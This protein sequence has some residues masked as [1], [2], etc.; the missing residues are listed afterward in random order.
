MRYDQ[1]QTLTKTENNDIKTFLLSH[2]LL[3]D[4]IGLAILVL[5]LHLSRYFTSPTH[6][7]ATLIYLAIVSNHLSFCVSFPL[8]HLSTFILI[9]TPISVVSTFLITYLNN[10][11]LFFLIL[12]EDTSLILPL[13][14][15]FYILSFFFV[16]SFIHL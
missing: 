9:T 10:L 16:T 12:S 14:Y 6:T 8:H 15:L 4:Y 13:T 5:D 11:C 1:K 7:P 2:H 3:F